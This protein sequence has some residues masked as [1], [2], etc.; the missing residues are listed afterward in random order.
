MEAVIEQGRTKK[1][2][3]FPIKENQRYYFDNEIFVV[4][5]KLTANQIKKKT[6]AKG[7]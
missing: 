1:Q 3:K 6:V 4:Y 7:N 5:L 2:Q